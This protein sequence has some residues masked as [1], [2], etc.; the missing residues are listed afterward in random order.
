MRA[1]A[2]KDLRH[3][4]FKELVKN[5]AFWDPRHPGSLGEMSWGF[6]SG[7]LRASANRCLLS[8][9]KALQKNQ[10]Q[11]CLMG[12]GQ[13]RDLRLTVSKA[14]GHAWFSDSREL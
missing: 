13:R 5:W 7:F 2:G 1:L 9:Q 3:H 10:T 6:Q 8:C 4:G 11:A 14:A 12:H